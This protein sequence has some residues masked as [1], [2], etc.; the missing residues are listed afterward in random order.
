MRS[1][2]S[3]LAALGVLACGS[4]T[5]PDGH[6]TPADAK[7]ITTDVPAFWSAFG[8]IKSVFDTV[9]MREYIDN[10]TV[11]LREFTALR[12]KN[13]TV[14][15]QSVWTLRDYYA[16]IRETTAAAAQME[17]QIRAAFAVADTLIDDAV[18]PDV[19]FAIGAMGTGG[20]TSNHGL[21][22]GIE[23]YSKAPDSPTG[24]LSP[25]QK[26]V[27]RS[28]DILPAVVAHELTHY[29]QRY[30][31][32]QT[33]LGQSIREGAADFIGRLLSG[34]TINEPVEAYG[35]AHEA[36]LWVDFQQEMNGTNYANWL[37]NGGEVTASSTRP[38]DLG[39]FIGARIVESYYRRATDKHA[40][41]QD[42]LRIRDFHVF[43]AASGYT[44]QP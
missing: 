13:A 10:G 2:L 33:L 34:R 19:Y 21:L 37:Y 7:I 23:L 22:I 26:S 38:A 3:L 25:W 32:T 9:P 14:L 30:G 4:A 12:W 43:L 5:E 16:S 20:T 28:N 40:A 6:A 27:I 42:I 11:G 18:F 44:G 8:R 35:I 39:Y 17:P 1:G 29:Q 24:V 36:Q 31:G 41:I 15:T